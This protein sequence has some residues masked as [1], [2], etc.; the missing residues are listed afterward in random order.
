MERYV[1]GQKAMDQLFVMEVH[2]AV[3]GEQSYNAIRDWAK[4]NLKPGELQAIDNQVRSGSSSELI[5]S[6]QGLQARMK[7]AGAVHA[8]VDGKAGAG[9]AAGDVY[10]SW[11]QAQADM[12]DPR[13]AKDP[14]FRA[15]VEAKIG[16]S[17]KLPTR[18][19]IV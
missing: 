3:G 2:N 8:F 13:Y 15:K 7:A 18:H 19:S 14:A 4:A 17:D 1:S 5:L 10:E 6:L 9:G 11:P 16:R 12:R